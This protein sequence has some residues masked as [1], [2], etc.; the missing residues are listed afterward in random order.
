MLLVD[1]LSQASNVL[2]FQLELGG[3]DEF[4]FYARLMNH[5]LILVA[6][7]CIMECNEVEVVCQRRCGNGKA[8]SKD[9]I[10]LSLLG[11]RKEGCAAKPEKSLSTP[12]LTTNTFVG[13]K[14]SSS[15]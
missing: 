10:L 1:S 12:K 3:N 8:V 4:C 15:F 5:S 2:W 11:S 7:T 13:H 14:A 9:N 6:G